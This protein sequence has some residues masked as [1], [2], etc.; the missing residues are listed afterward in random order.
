META[1]GSPMSFESDLQASPAM[2]RPLTTPPPSSRLSHTPR[3]RHHS[4]VA[5]NTKEFHTLAT[6]FGW[7][8][9]SG[10]SDPCHDLHK[11]ADE[12]DIC[13]SQ[14]F[15]DSQPIACES[16]DDTDLDGIL[17]HGDLV[18]WNTL[19]DS[20][21]F[22]RDSEL[23]DYPQDSIQDQQYSNDVAEY[24]PGASGLGLLST[25][26]QQGL[27]SHFGHQMRGLRSPCKDG[28]RERVSI[29][30]TMS[31]V[32]YVASRSISTQD[33]S[34]DAS[35][36]TEQMCSQDVVLSSK[37]LEKKAY[38]RDIERPFLSHA[39]GIPLMV[40]TRLESFTTSI[41][42]R[43][44]SQTHG[45]DS[46][47]ISLK[48]SF[49]NR[50]L[51]TIPIEQE[52]AESS[53]DCTDDSTGLT[54]QEGIHLDADFEQR[55]ECKTPSPDVLSA[56][57]TEMHINPP[58]Y[59]EIDSRVFDHT[60]DEGL[61]NIIYVPQETV[62]RDPF[63]GTS[64]VRPIIAATIVKLIEKL[65]HQ[66]GMD[67]GFLSDF[68]L[69]YRLF[70]SPVQLC[71]YLIQRYLWALE[72]DT[73]SRCVVRVRTFVVFR[74]WINNHFAD[75][76]LTSKSLRFQM[77]SFLNSMRSHS[78]V[79]ASPRDSRIIRSLMDFFKHQRRYY[80]NLAER[81]LAEQ[82]SEL[83]KRDSQQDCQRISH[84]TETEDRKASE[85]ERLE[86]SPV[87][88]HIGSSV[89]KGTS[90]DS[91]SS[92]RQPPPV[93]GRHRASTLAGPT[94]RS[95]TGEPHGSHPTP[96]KPISSE[97]RAQSMS[98]QLSEGGAVAA[99]E[100]RLSTS[101]NK[102]TKSANWSTKMSMGFNKL[103]QKSEDIYQQF[104]HPAS[105]PSKSDNRT[106]VCWTPAYTGV[107]E[108][109][110]LNTTR[111]HPSLKPSVVITNVGHESTS[112]QLPA[113]QTSF[114]LPSYK[115]M[116]RLK[117]PINLG[118][119]S[120]AVMPSP[121]PSPTRNQFSSMSNRHSR[122]NSNS[123]VGYHP[124]PDCPYHVLSL[125]STSRDTAKK[126]QEALDRNACTTLKEALLDDY[127]DLLPQSHFAATSSS[128]PTSPGWQY[129]PLP[130]TSQQTGMDDTPVYKPFILCYRSQMIAQQLCLLEEHFLEQIRWDELLEVEL[131]KAGRKNRSKNQPSIGGYLFKT[132][133]EWNG[134][135]ASN[136]RS[137]MLC[138]WVASEVVSTH[139]IEDRVRVIEK[140]IR[141]AQHLIHLDPT[142]DTAN[143]SSLKFR[144]RNKGA[145]HF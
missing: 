72:Q 42:E 100:R 1:L 136:E 79:Q 63:S 83:G 4:C 3:R 135:K 66:Y 6:I 143:V 74:Y 115:P 53:L 142:L 108:N 138:M 82:K 98:R 81:S 45:K 144:W 31:G 125:C 139:P 67:S 13:S 38:G 8:T 44:L 14:Y 25:A 55:T 145:F 26:V 16:D 137:N 61:H 80:K 48:S 60:E 56:S 27:H 97:S 43:S 119:S 86:V 90:N 52:S 141:I 57:Q 71:K 76:F 102:S 85:V 126:P 120:P 127:E 5:P 124:N 68:F 30:I 64:E 99:R 22:L 89:I 130:T 33:T 2:D 101:S 28:G 23:G 84:F 109:N 35:P 78:R 107:T 29:P 75:D 47:Y 65:T 118:L 20:S 39:N 10:W 62:K 18:E 59:L 104:V 36:A 77:A 116:K 7:V 41:N 46:G 94:P 11:G 129:C 95:A 110:A 134:M 24:L 131:I 12:P 93:K 9:L 128:I 113:P 50:P 132:N 54:M 51:E 17:P 88:N 122:T 70:M 92:L 69:T 117:S 111:S 32:D 114:G 103:R 121:V 37:G 73:E 96:S 140:F 21:S 58:R 91:T 112:P 106:C 19:L 105:L 34:M 87:P 123:S 133:G 15:S 49:L 40:E